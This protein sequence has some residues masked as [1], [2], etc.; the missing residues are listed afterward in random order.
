MVRRRE[1]VIG[2]LLVW[3]MLLV[4]MGMLIDRLNYSRVDSVY[5]WFNAS[6]VVTGADPAEAQ[7]LIDS[8]RELSN[9][10]YLETRHFAQ[11]ELSSYTP[12]FI[13][14]F[15][16]LLL[17]GVLATFFIWRSVVVPVA[18]A[19]LDL[20]QPERSTQPMRS[21]LSDDGELLDSDLPQAQYNGQE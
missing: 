19:D 13:L 4:S 18:V 15:G 20:G 6:N 3:V 21:L 14:V 12:L 8:A 11:L 16:L 7:R 10:V 5:H 1:R 2:T 17:G 9:T